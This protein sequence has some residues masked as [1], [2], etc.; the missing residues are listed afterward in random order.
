MKKFIRGCLNLTFI[1]YIFSYLLIMIALFAGFFIIM[2]TQLVEQHFSDKLLEIEANADRCMTQVNENLLYLSQ[3]S[4]AIRENVNIIKLH[5]REDSSQYTLEKELQKYDTSSVLINSIVYY[6]K[7]AVATTYIPVTYQDGVFRLYKNMEKPLIWDPTPY[8]G[9]KKNQLILVADD[10]SQVLIYLPADI[11]EKKDLIYFFVLDTDEFEKSLYNLISVDSPAV[12]LIDSDRKVMA[13]VNEELLYPY[14]D[15][16]V[17]EDGYYER[18]D[19]DLL[20]V[21]KGSSNGLALITLVEKEYQVDKISDSLIRSYG[22]LFLLGIIVCFLLFAAMK[23]TYYPLLKLTKKHMS[24][25]NSEKD[26]IRQLDSIIMQSEERRIEMDGKL[27]KY[28]NAMQKSLVES[29]LFDAMECEMSEIS[30]ID[31][32]FDLDE[33]TEIFMIY[34][35]KTLQEKDVLEYLM[36]DLDGNGT[37]MIL[38]KD[39]DNMILLLK[40]IRDKQSTY[41]I[42][43]ANL[44]QLYEKLGCFSVIAAVNSFLDIPLFYE[45]VRNAS[46]S[47]SECR[48]VLNCNSMEFLSDITEYP[49]DLLEQLSETLEEA[50]FTEV[51]HLLEQLFQILDVAAMEKA[52]LSYYFSK[53]IL[54]DILTIIMNVINQSDIQ[55]QTCSEL[56]YETLYLCRSF[57]YYE[58]QDSIKKQILQLISVYEQEKGR[59]VSLEQMKK[60]VE[61]YY[62]DPNFSI[63]VLAEHFGISI[64]YMSNLFRTELDN[65]FSDYL[66]TLRF[67]KAK[68]LLISGNMTIDEISCAVGYTNAS[69]FRRKFKQETGMTPIQ[70]QALYKE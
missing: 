7:N 11:S 4:T 54:I 67:R 13:G 12:V 43:T 61:Q 65:T 53:C 19:M 50:D 51:C 6:T 21:R 15:A 64:S 70:F 41:E 17:M 2:R 32:F 22:M 45:K 10:T 48:A 47:W 46:F 1:K 14:L 34:V 44:N 66:W 36:N 5:Y 42:L 62:C 33:M 20:Y 24:S 59:I 49:H 58:E 60:M 27:K 35:Q 55:F 40:A 8:L 26:C 28:R 56:Y 18:E 38:G 29:V 69:S 16:M 39:N 23:I 52:Q 63:Q 57:S 3:M 25:E 9:L 31:E 37:Y 68:E 30:A